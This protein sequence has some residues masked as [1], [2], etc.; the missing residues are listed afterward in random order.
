MR[1]SKRTIVVAM[2]Q[3]VLILICCDLST[4]FVTAQTNSTVKRAGDASAGY[5]ASERTGSEF[6]QREARYRLRP[7]DTLELEFAFSPEFNQTVI[8]G[9]DGFVTFRG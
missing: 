1:P 8:V 6:S 2:I 9:P 4:V 3:L 5:A 7:G